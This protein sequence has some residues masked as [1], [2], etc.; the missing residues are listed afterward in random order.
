MMG[1][2]QHSLASWHSSILGGPQE[3]DVGGYRDYASATSHYEGQHRAVYGSA[4][5]SGA[6]QGILTESLGK[7]LNDH[8]FTLVEGIVDAGKNSGNTGSCEELLGGDEEGE[9]SVASVEDQRKE[10]TIYEKFIMGIGSH[11]QYSQDV[12]RS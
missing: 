5:M 1:G 11:S 2:S 8:V 10:M 6:Q 7:D 4:S 12:L 3:A 9:R